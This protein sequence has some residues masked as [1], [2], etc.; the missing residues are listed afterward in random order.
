MTAEER[1]A[2][3]AALRRELDAWWSTGL[4]LVTLWQ[5]G[6]AEA[7]IAIRAVRDR[8]GDVA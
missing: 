1:G 2:A 4:D 5:I 6:N 3:N 8:K 7:A